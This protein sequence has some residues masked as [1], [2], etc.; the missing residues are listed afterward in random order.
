M[1]ERAGICRGSARRGGGV[2]AYACLAELPANERR[3][4]ARNRKIFALYVT[5]MCRADSAR[6]ASRARRERLIRLR[7]PAELFYFYPGRAA[8]GPRPPARRP[9]SRRI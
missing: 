2:R 1:R 9:N 3:L 7:R 8:P 5:R 4:A 6:A